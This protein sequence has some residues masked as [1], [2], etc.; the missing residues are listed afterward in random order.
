MYVSTLIVREK[1]LMPR[2]KLDVLKTLN[3]NDRRVVHDF[4][5]G[6]EAKAVFL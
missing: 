1:V 5:R 6:R 2:K 4:G 3:Q